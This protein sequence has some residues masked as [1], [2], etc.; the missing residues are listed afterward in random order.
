MASNKH[1]GSTLDN[2]LAEEG[3]LEAFT[4][5]AIKEVFAWQVAQRMKERGLSKGDMAGKMQ[6]SRSQIDRLL[7]PT[8]KNVT[9]ATMY[10]AA[11]ALGE[12]LTVSLEPRATK[13]W[14]VRRAADPGHWPVKNVKTVKPK[15]KK[16]A[17]GTSRVLGNNA[18]ARV[19]A[20]KVI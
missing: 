6:T 12:Q 1:I 9:L 19:A 2:F 4:A 13:K 3:C 17:K 18:P 20:R 16:P 10:K 15:S 5:V 11:V 8:D 7:D 14:I